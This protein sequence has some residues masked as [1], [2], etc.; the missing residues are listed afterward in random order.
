[1]S[2]KQETNYGPSKLDYLIF[3]LFRWWWNP[4]LREHPRM[5]I[6]FATWMLEWVERHNGIEAADEEQ[7][8]RLTKIAGANTMTFEVRRDLPD[9]ATTSA[10]PHNALE[11]ARA[12]ARVRPN[13]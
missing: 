1:M 13:V 5:A 12:L 10:I 4:I 11:D 8:K 7:L 6:E 3:R 9:T 2:D